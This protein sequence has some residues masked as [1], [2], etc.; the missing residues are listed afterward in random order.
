[1]YRLT[2][3]T[4]VLIFL[5]PSLKL[6]SGIAA[7]LKSEID[8]KKR[9]PIGQNITTIKRDYVQHLIKLNIPIYKFNLKLHEKPIHLGVCNAFNNLTLIFFVT[10]IKNTV[11]SSIR[12]WIRTAYRRNVSSLDLF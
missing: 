2:L 1:M 9:T 8:H 10:T 11:I 6:V 7:S 5:K 4:M 12:K 3:T